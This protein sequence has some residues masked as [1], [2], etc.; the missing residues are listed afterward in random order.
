M[1]AAVLVLLGVIA[2]AVRLDAPADGTVTSFW[3]VDGVIIDVLSTST[4]QSLQSGDVI[5]EIAGHRLADGLGGLAR[6]ALG[7]QLSYDIV[8][9]IRNR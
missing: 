5:I 9:A 2:V 6:P 3:Q 7:D 1:I 4:S 8:R